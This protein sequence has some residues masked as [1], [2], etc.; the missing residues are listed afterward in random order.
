VALRVVIEVAPGF[1]FPL[2][3]S[4]SGDDDDVDDVDDDDVDDVDDDEEV[5]D[6]DTVLLNGGR[7]GVE[8]ED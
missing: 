4:F 7:E 8:V 3:A 5:D 2:Y 1:P 6:V